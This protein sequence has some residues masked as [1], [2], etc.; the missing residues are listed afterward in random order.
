MTKPL[1]R[2]FKVTMQAR[3]ARDPKYRKSLRREG[4]E[5]ARAR[6]VSK[7]AIMAPANAWLG[8]LIRQSPAFEAK[9]AAEVAAINIAPELAALREARGLSHAQL[10]ARV[11][12]TRSAIARLA[13]AQ[14]DNVQLKTPQRTPDA[15]GAP[16]AGPGRPR[17][18]GPA[19]STALAAGCRT[20]AAPSAS[21]AGPAPAWPRT[22]GRIGG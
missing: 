11:G 10:A 4:V 21:P 22:S 9:V 3:I 19:W 5:L 2:D 17:R 16:P 15:L 7:R 1:T 12:V 18:G 20:R 6:P 13:S 14:P 8:R